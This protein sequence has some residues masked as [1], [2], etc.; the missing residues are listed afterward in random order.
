M[1]RTLVESDGQPY[2]YHDLLVA[3]RARQAELGSCRTA[4]A[5]SV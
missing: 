5:E 2:G 1:P 3:L 4:V